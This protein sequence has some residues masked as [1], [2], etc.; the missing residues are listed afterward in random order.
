[1]KGFAMKSN[2]MNTLLLE[3]MMAVLFFALSAVVILEVF[4]SGY[5]LNEKAGVT[6]A[7]ANSARN[8]SQQICAAD[9]FAALLVQEGFYNENGSWHKNCGEYALLV[10]T[11]S[12]TYAVGSMQTAQIAAVYNEEVLVSLPCAR[13]IA[14]EVNP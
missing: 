9:D 12:E 11:G 6:G 2:R 10:K 14:G 1:M 3:I 8:L 7:A 13:Y 5:S 4:V